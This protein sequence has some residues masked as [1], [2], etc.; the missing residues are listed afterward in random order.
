LVEKETDEF[1]VPGVDEVGTVG[2]EM[3]TVRSLLFEAV[4]IT[5][6]LTGNEPE[7]LQAGPV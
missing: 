1:A 2:P 5:V 3:F 6:P 7:P 4:T